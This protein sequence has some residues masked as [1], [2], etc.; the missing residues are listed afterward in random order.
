MRYLAKGVG[1]LSILAI[2]LLA[3]G[4]DIK[5]SGIPRALNTDKMLRAAGNAQGITIGAV[6]AGENRQS[7]AV[8]SERQFTITISSGT[9]GQ[10]LAGFRD[11][12][13][14]T[15]ESMGGTIHGRGLWGNEKDVRAFTYDYRWSGNEGIV[16]V[17]SFGETGGSIEI[18]MFCYE[19]K[20]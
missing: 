10:L 8:S 16:R 1:I 19:H 11:E 5:D 15:I 9:P 4:C 3:C 17:H 14:R 7:F 2:A 18:S 12:V 20:R 6:G 13:K